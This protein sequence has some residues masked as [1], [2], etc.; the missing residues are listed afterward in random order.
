MA[1]GIKEKT[2]QAPREA[3]I[4]EAL[5]RI[6]ATDIPGDM[7][8]YSGLTRIRGV[9]WAFS[10]ALCYTLGI[11]KGKKISDLNPQEIEKINVFLRNPKLPEW[12]LN[13]RKDYETGV[14][15]HVLTNDLD[16][17]KENDIRRLKKIKSYKGW[18]HATGQPV[19]GQRTKSHFRNEGAVGVRKGKT[20]KAVAAEATAKKK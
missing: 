7:S 1:S 17:A 19:R 3:F 9:S 18:R 12:L 16:M 2:K 11:P 13:R 8:T 14:T 5:V 10:N 15:K 20:A 6:L 4:E